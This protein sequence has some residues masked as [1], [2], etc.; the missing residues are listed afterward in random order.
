MKLIDTIPNK[1]LLLLFCALSIFF[2]FFAPNFFSA[3]NVESILAGYSFLAILAIGQGLTILVRG[4]DLSIGSN[5]AL[6]AM[7][8]FDLVMIFNWP[9]YWAILG[10]ITVTTFAGI[11]NALLIIHLRLQPFVATLATLAAF[12][13]L[14][15]AISGRQLF[16]ELSSQAIRDPW[17]SFFGEFVDLSGFFAVDI[18]LPWIPVS[19]LVLLV[20][21]ICIQTL[22]Y[23]T[24]LGLNLRTLGGNTEAAHLAGLPIN[25]LLICAYALAGLTA[26]LAAVILVARLTTATEAL[27]TGM[28]L[29]VIA[30][31][32]IGGV[33]LQGG[34]GNA[35]GPA[36]GAFLLGIIL[37]GLT[38]LGVSQFIQQ[39]ITGLI[40]ITAVW[41]D[42]MI[43]QKNTTRQDYE[44]A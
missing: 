18:N 37:I 3:G 44:A 23:K 40:L 43:S 7:V 28:E 14:V 2:S 11:L 29:T 19:F 25:R 33:S 21:V 6:G 41:Y 30:A 20:F 16:P 39:I 9:G 24:R 4:I 32:I 31:A 13:G 1:D 36:L 42:R 8:I 17:I 26:G 12:R 34:S 27:G 10:A 15:Y 38:L 5:V 35:I 22:L